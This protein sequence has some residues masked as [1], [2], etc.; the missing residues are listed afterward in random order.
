M[1]RGAGSTT[2]FP[3]R[4]PA[5]G[6]PDQVVIRYAWGAAAN[7]IWLQGKELA[8]GRYPWL[9]TVSPTGK[10][11]QIGHVPHP[12]AIANFPQLGAGGR[13]ETARQRPSLSF[14]IRL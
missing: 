1:I 13:K 8:T 12:Q 3:S 14:C 2:A 9:E 7:C 4:V 10:T 5:P 11:R 6:W